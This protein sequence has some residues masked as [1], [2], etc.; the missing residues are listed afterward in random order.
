MKQF[1]LLVALSTAVAAQ[2]S[3]KAGAAKVN[4]TPRE[5]IWLAGYGDRTR[6]SEGVRQDIYAKAL[7]LQDSDNVTSVIVTAD[8]LGFTREVAE[9]IADRARQKFGLPRERLVF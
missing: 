6:P 1:V 2:T 4:I 3:W 8:L 9:P 7:A 5:S